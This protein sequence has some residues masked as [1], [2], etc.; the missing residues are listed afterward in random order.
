LGAVSFGHF[1][2]F[3]GPLSSGGYW[4]FCGSGFYFFQIFS[5][6]PVNLLTIKKLYLKKAENPQVSFYE[7]RFYFREPEFIFMTTNF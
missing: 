1:F 6:A 3:L 5:P 7:A 4:R 2:N